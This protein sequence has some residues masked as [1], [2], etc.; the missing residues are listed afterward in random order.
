MKIIFFL[1]GLISASTAFAQTIDVD[2]Q[3]S[4]DEANAQIAALSAR[5]QHFAGQ[6]GALNKRINELQQQIKALKEPGNI[7]APGS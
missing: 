3:A 6:S 5:A 1:F 4:L 7:P 2:V